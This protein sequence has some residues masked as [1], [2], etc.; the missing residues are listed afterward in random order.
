V[1]AARAAITI[2]S[3]SFC[4]SLGYAALSVPPMALSIFMSFL[5]PWE[6]FFRHVLVSL[7]VFNCHADAGFF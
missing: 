4:F 1:Q 7:D 2:F 5:G 6:D 3:I